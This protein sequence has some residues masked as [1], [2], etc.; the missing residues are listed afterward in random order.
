MR[1]TSPATCL[2]SWYVFKL[3][4][5]C[6]KGGR[7]TALIHT[8]KKKFG[9]EEKPRPKHTCDYIHAGIG[10]LAATLCIYDVV[11]RCG[12]FI[13]E[14]I[15]SGT[16]GWSPQLGGVMTNGTCDA[17]RVAGVNGNGKVTR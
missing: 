4:L 17:G 2:P 13:K 7:T 14:V 8:N 16:S 12:S 6:G 5:A 15:F 3:Y 11:Q 9:A 1:C 10:P